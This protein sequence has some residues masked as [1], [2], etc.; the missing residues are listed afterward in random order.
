[1]SCLQP[2]CGAYYFLLDKCME[3]LHWI[4]WLLMLE[5]YLNKCVGTQGN[6]HKF[7]IFMVQDFCNREPYMLDNFNFRQRIT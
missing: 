6:G 7:I 3:I 5:V 4:L 1:M 2:F